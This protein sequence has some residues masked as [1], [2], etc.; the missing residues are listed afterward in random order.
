MADTMKIEAIKS[1]LEKEFPG[2]MFSVTSISS[3][4]VY[5]FTVTGQGIPRVA[6]VRYSF[7]SVCESA[8]VSG[9][10]E[11]FTLAEHLREMG[12]TPVVVT[13][14]GLKLEED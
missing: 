5:V 6:K 1:Y 2:Q 11:A 3:E 8:D 4:K 10:L 7:L 13:S 14:N 12:G 9:I